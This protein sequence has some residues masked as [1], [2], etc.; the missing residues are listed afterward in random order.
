MF[1]LDTHIL[2]WFLND[3]PM[4]PSEIRQLIGR[5]RDIAVFVSVAFFWEMAIKI[6]KGKLTLNQSIPHL[7]NFCHEVLHLPVLEIRDIHLE[8]L[9]TLPWFHKDPF[10]RL[11][12]S[13]A[14]AE[15][16]TLISVDRRVED[17]PVRKLWEA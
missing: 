5:S 1:L 4:L 13:Q 6:S 16:M 10:D 11:I 9:R 15:D 17:Y 7:M 2:I 8:T 14:I 12:I 3:D